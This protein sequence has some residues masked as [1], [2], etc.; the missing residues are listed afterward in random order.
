MSEKRGKFEP[1]WVSPPGDTIA[2]IL[3]ERDWTQQ[4]FANRMGYSTKHISLLINGKVPITQDTAMRLERVLGSSAGFWLTR[5]AQYRETEAR[6]K[7]IKRLESW[8]PWALSMPVREL[9]NT[10]VI[11]K[12]RVS[13]SNNLDIVN[14]LLGFF[15]VASPDDW[16]KQ[17]GA[18]AASFRRTK[19][20]QSDTGAI[21]SW[22]RLG[23]IVAEKTAGPKYNRVKFEASLAKIRA[24]TTL[25]PAEFDPMLRDL[26]RISGV[27][28]VY[29]PSIPGAHVSGASRW[30]NLHKPIIQLSLYG[31][32]NDR[33]WFTFFHEA[34]HILKHGKDA[35]FLDELEGPRLDSDEEREADQW[36][37]HILIPAESQDELRRL[38]SKKSVQEFAQKIGIHPG[39]VV[40]RMQHEHIIPYNQMNSLK[41]HFE[42][43]NT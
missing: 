33:F 14:D 10:G 13:E 17:Y 43:S 12:R 36:A 27:I 38:N 26:C 19:I 22:L 31:K 4:D 40:G 8:V 2:D 32:M 21:S 23:E 18:K 29:I 1:D 35:V 6:F 25:S 9:M 39:I 37:S 41:V 42:F 30:L 7:E 11:T 20:E 28:L 3:E 34:A 15:G 24:F 16:K 5:E